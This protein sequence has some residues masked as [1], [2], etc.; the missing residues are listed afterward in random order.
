[1]GALAG[2]AVTLAAAVTVTTAV[3]IYTPHYRPTLRLL[4]EVVPAGG[5]MGFVQA[6]PPAKPCPQTQVRVLWRWDARH[7]QREVYPLSDAHLVPRLWEGPTTIMVA[8]PRDV[9]PGDYNYVRYSQTWCS[10][11]NYAFGPTTT[12]TR[13]VPVR[14]VPPVDA[15]KG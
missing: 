15:D 6:V 1:M 12:W 10:W 2:V 13:D 9:P 7:A 5:H 4:T 8:V 11:I 3:N 14:I